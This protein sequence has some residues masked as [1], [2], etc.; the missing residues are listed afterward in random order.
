M[1]TLPDTPKATFL[2]FILKLISKLIVHFIEKAGKNK[3][4]TQAQLK[5]WKDSYAQKRADRAVKFNN[6][7][8]SVRKEDDK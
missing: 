5:S 1:V 7:H 2:D 3:Q 6:L 4:K 8:N